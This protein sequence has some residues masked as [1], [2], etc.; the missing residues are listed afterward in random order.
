MSIPVYK[1]GWLYLLCTPFGVSCTDV[2][3]ICCGHGVSVME[4]VRNP[5]RDSSFPIFIRVEIE[6][7]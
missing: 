7:I 6:T 1:E 5:G 2:H 3:S 4:D